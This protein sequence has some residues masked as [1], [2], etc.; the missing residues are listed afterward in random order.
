MKYRLETGGSCSIAPAGRTLM[1]GDEERYR[2]FAQ[3]LPGV[4]IVLNQH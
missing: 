2:D 1:Q 4:G 3:A